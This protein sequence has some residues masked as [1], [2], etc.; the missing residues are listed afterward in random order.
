MRG[1]GSV[2]CWAMMVGKDIRMGSGLCYIVLYC[3][4][5]G[6]VWDMV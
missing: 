5:F 6:V 3:A 4:M 1:G 2:V